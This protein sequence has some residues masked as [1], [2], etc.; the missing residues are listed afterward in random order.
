VRAFIVG[1]VMF[2]ALGSIAARQQPPV[3]VPAP[4]VTGPIALTTALRDVA[5]G[6]PYNAT[7]MDLAK[8]GYV[9]EEFVLQ[10]TAS[11]YNTPAGE[12]GSVADSGHPY[13]TR[14]VVRRPKSAARFNGTVVVEWY[15]VSQGHD[16]EYDWFQSMDHLV[17][18]GY[19]WAGVSNQA[20]GVS[21]L[22]EWSPKRYGTLDVTD[23][24]SV[25]GDGLS[26]DIFTAAALAIRGKAGSDVMGGLKAARLVAVGHSQS[27]G[28]LYTYFH[29]VHPLV[30]PAYDAVILHGGGGRIRGD[31]NVKVFK[32]L[33]ETDV[34]GQVN[35]RQPDTDRFR[36]WEIAGSSHLT[37]QFSRAMAGVGLRVSGMVPVEGSPSIEGPTISG[38]AGNGAAGNG[39]GEANA[40]QNGGCEKPPFS[41]VPSH[42]ALNAAFDHVARWVKD[43]YPPPSA[44]PVDVKEAPADQTA[45]GSP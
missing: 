21:S 5:H 13:K 39:A 10:G 19:A 6:Y 34:P 26:Y 29:S 2:V 8:L 17:R 1:C 45:A 7:P 22:R 15:N 12:T 40:G 37:A 20:V 24:G 42:F 41:R 28:R 38:G 32:F 25:M 30:P 14:I 23:N 44:P 4:S 43:G 36:Q 11:R 31:L 9:E 35:N 16:G 27:A 18:A 33:D 3:N